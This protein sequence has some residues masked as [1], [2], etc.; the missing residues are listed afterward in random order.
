MST[1][2]RQVL[3]I[4][5]MVPGDAPN[6]QPAR[7]LIQTEHGHVPPCLPPLSAWVGL[8][9]Q[10]HAPLSLCAQNATSQ[11]AGSHSRPLPP[12]V[13]P[14]FTPRLRACRVSRHKCRR[15]IHRLCRPSFLAASDS[16]L[17]VPFA[18]SI[19]AGSSCIWGFGL[20]R[21]D[22]M[23]RAQTRSHYYRLSSRGW[24]ELIRLRCR[25]GGAVGLCDSM[26]Q[27]SHKVCLAQRRRKRAQSPTAACSL[28]D[29]PSHFWQHLH[30][31][32]HSA[33]IGASDA[34]I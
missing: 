12:S 19:L 2:S 26:A 32:S 29:T 6:I 13:G 15:N 1:L 4:L 17:P 24:R 16:I 34:S 27:G 5:A 8:V 7:Y 23:P 31:W 3:C 18:C 30:Q 21:G 20:L 33:I 9:G 25:R 10:S 22:V 11:P 14:P 28:P